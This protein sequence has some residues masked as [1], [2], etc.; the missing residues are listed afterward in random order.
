MVLV[1]ALL[2]AALGASALRTGDAANIAGDDAMRLVGAI[3][4][5]EGQ[6]WFDTLQHRDNTPLGASMHFSRLID[7]PLALLIALFTPL[8]GAQAPWWAAFVWPLLVLLVVAALVASLAERLSGPSAR[9]PALALLAMT[10]PVYTEFVPG[11]V[12]HHNVQ[13]ALTL[14]II[15][16]TIEGRHSLKWSAA[17]A[18]LAAAGIAVGTEIL[19]SVIGLL[20]Y[21]ALH[22]ALDP[23]IA[24]GPLVAVAIAFPVALLVLLLG[25][26][27][28]Q[29][30][31]NPACD[32][33]SPVYLVAGLLYGAACLGAIAV[34]RR[35]T[36]PLH[37]LLAL[38]VLGVAALAILLV[39]FPD[40]R[41]GPY[42][43]F[44]PELA[45]ILLPQI[46]E[47]QPVWVWAAEWRPQLVLLFAPLAGMVAIAVAILFTTGERRARLVVLGGFCVL[48]FVV[49]LLQVRG[50]RLL[51]IAL[52]PVGGVVVAAAW[53]RFRARQSLGSA[54]LASLAIFAFASVAQWTLAIGALSGVRAGPG[55][56]HA[57]AW[58]ACNARAA[59][60]PLAALPP[61]RVMA[62]VMIGPQLLLETPH[63]VVSAGYHRNEEGLRD[64]VRFF[65]G[66]EA[67]ARAV[68][69]ERQLDYLVFCR[70]ISPSDGLA[71]VA[72]FAP[73]DWSWLTPVSAPEAPIQIYAIAR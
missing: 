52:V 48:L 8:A 44:D 21:V 68:A 15:L 11:R 73:T 18:A 49:S 71:G 36:A 38:A 4:L 56:S 14:G 45:A 70:N 35:A 61:S 62:Y 6:S 58:A 10:L 7:G 23:K 57:A 28:P 39:L 41:R 17:A 19:P 29:S 63:S 55:D 24:R 1:W 33:L 60:A 12:D 31:L 3:D 13:V 72:P 34:T 69:E 30:W 47:A 53:A 9:L 42:G 51:A 40:C 25:T 43:N 65:G 2:A 16:A 26:M 20:A 67:V 37:R 59:F 5:F 64:T 27:P 66:G 22:W 32:A 50:V 54:A 46:G